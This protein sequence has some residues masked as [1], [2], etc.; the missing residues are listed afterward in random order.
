MFVILQSFQA[1][2]KRRTSSRVG[3]R[4]KVPNALTFNALPLPVKSF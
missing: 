3:G 4:I 2:T 1:V